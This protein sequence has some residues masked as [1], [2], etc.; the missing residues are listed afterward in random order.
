MS[1]YNEGETLLGNRTR[2][3]LESM[4]AYGYDVTSHVEEFRDLFVDQGGSGRALKRDIAIQLM[5]E[6]NRLTMLSFSALS[7]VRD[8]SRKTRWEVRFKSEHLNAGYL[9]KIIDPADWLLDQHAKTDGGLA[10]LVRPV[11]INTG[12]AIHREQADALLAVLNV[13]DIKADPELAPS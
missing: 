6:V 5:S 2:D 13:A 1:R 7:E 8:D 3:L 10:D 4:K 12:I 11:E 9:F